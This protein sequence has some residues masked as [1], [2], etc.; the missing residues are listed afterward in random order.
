MP[1]CSPSNYR[2]TRSNLLQATKI[3][4]KKLPNYV[5]L[6]KKL[7]A[8]HT[9]HRQKLDLEQF[10]RLCLHCLGFHSSSIQRYTV[11]KMLF[12]FVQFIIPGWLTGAARV[13]CR[14]WRTPAILWAKSR[15]N[16]GNT[17]PLLRGSTQHNQQRKKNI[18]VHK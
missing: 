14:N 15:N 18:Y 9:K 1:T 10:F 13:N 8:L 12:S 2:Q 17:P 6:Q 11:K 4:L 7:Y 16:P 5:H 3:F